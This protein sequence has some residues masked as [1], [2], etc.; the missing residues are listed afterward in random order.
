MVSNRDA[1]PIRVFI[2]DDNAGIRKALGR[3][4]KAAD[5]MDLI[6]EA[7][8]ADEA[9]AVVGHLEPDV[10][11]M[12]LSMPGTN[13]F[14]AT[15]E[16]LTA[17]PVMKVVMYSA[18]TAAENRITADAAGVSAY[19]SKSGPPDA[20]VDAVRAVMTTGATHD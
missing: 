3:L 10:V 4:I 7:G 13:G 9:L 6:G 16:L 19:V 18:F 20:A 11:I 15:K 2:C 14:D 1:N 5:D 17:H 8:S 12:D